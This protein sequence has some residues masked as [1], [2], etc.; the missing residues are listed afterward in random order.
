MDGSYCLG[1]SLIYFF[2]L[3]YWGHIHMNSSLTPTIRVL[4]GFFLI[5]MKTSMYLQELRT[6]LGVK[7]HNKRVSED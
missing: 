3:F 6:I 4:Q 5:E 7:H 1:Y 2:I